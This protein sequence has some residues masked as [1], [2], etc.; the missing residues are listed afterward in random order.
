M[1]SKAEPEACEE[2]GEE[3]SPKAVDEAVEPSSEEEAPGDA[4]P[5]AILKAPALPE[6]ALKYGK[7]EQCICS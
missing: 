2:G 1:R 6:G 3:E 5:A 4:M 7:Q